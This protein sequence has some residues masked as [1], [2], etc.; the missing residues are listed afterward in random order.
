MI[1]DV[2]MHLGDFLHTNGAHIIGEKIPF[3]KK[4]NIQ[5][6][7]E[8]IL[9]FNSFGWTKR[10]F[11]KYDDAYTASVQNRIK[12]ATY[13]NLLK[14]YSILE[15]YSVSILGD[16][17]VSSFCMPIAPY[18]SM[19]DIQEWTHKDHRLMPFTSIDV[20]LSS[21][22]ACERIA[23]QMDSCYGIKLHPIIQGLPFDSELTFS[24]LDLFKT[25]GKPVLFHAGGSRYYLGNE[26]PLQ[27]CELDNI[28][29]ARSMVSRYPEI[30]FIIGHGGI[31]EYKE[32]CLAMS[33]F[34]NVFLDITVQSVSSIRYLLS[35]Y[36][37]DRILFAT[38]WPCVNPKTTLKIVTKA[39]TF[40]Q[41]EKCLYRNAKNLFGL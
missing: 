3:P 39:L 41:L 10:L 40:P 32:W 4:F 1:I 15:D 31:A 26:K 9:K 36:G 27:H 8:N 25:T 28:Q 29:A 7:E 34:E 35:Q 21:K 5:A 37:E 22:E 14:Y 30:P 38:E 33:E 12:A 2:H 23:D 18:V 24:V 6:F 17:N 19:D 11:E 13:E 20:S 16:N